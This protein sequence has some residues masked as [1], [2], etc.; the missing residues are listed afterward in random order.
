MASFHI[1]PPESFNFTQDEWPKWVR[2]FERFLQG[3]GLKSK[4]EEHQVN[5]LI[6]IMGD[7]ADDI[8]WVISRRKESLR[9]RKSKV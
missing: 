2:R 3:L 7:K 8:L 1:S 4:S 6:Y 5:A 9:H